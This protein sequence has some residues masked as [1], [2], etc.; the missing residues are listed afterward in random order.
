KRDKGMRMVKRHRRVERY[1]HPERK[2]RAERRGRR[3]GEIILFRENER[4]LGVAGKKSGAP[5]VKKQKAD[6]K[7]V[8]NAALR[9][10]HGQ[11]ETFP[12]D[13]ICALVIQEIEGLKNREAR[14]ATIKKKRGKPEI[15]AP[16]I[17]RVERS[18]GGDK[19]HPDTARDN[20]DTQTGKQRVEYVHAGGIR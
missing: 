1:F 8:E 14:D 5:L 17:K 20:A 15:A 9:D 3:L 4:R 13:V 18:D 19:S 12:R 6:G 11:G 10:D 2:W 16:A 7:G